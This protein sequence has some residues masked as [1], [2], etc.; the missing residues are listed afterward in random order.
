MAR[1]KPVAIILPRMA[2]TMVHNA[3]KK[4]NGY[5]SFATG[6]VDCFIE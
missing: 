3:A 2:E 5:P 6:I 1:Q 4:I